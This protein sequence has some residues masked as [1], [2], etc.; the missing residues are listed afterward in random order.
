MPY[1]T[2]IERLGIEKGREEGREEG[3]LQNAKESVIEVLEERF[4]ILSND[5]RDAINNLHNLPQL[6][7]LHKRAITIS[8]LEEFQEL[9]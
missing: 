3:S 5:L 7:Q 2:S 4:S 6:K 8:S 9:L 1:V